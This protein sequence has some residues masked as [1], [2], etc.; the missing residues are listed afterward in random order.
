MNTALNKGH[1]T[2]RQAVPL[3]PIVR[4]A[5]SDGVILKA[6]QS[7][8]EELDGADAQ[9]LADAYGQGYT[10]GFELAKEL[11]R[12]HGWDIELMT[13]E[14]LDSMD[15]EVGQ[16]H[17]KVC[18]VWFEENNIQPPL[19]IGTAIQEGAITGICEHSVARYLVKEN[20]CA[21]DGRWLLIKFENAKAA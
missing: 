5:V 21:Q 6:A 20:G 13:I 15:F 7:I 18:K 2:T 17:E 1:E 12:W 10:T 19:P 16:E 14:V 9:S 11:E 8:C 4:P 3:K